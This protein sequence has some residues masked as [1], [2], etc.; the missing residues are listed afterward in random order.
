MKIL[1]KISISS[2]ASGLDFTIRTVLD[3]PI[4]AASQIDRALDTVLFEGK[5]VYIGISSTIAGLLMPMSSPSQASTS[6]VSATQ[7]TTQTSPRSQNS[8]VGASPSMQAATSGSRSS[9]AHTQRREQ[10]S[11]QDVDEA[12]KAGRWP[13][14]LSFN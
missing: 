6:S 3:S 2:I 5:S 7:P 1:T 9:G 13:I 14:Q 8:N 12:A 4:T 10:T 11:T